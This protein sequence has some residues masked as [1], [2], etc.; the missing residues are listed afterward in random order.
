MHLLYIGWG[1]GLGRSGAEMGQ[2]TGCWGCGNDP[3]GSMKC[4][5]LVDQLWNEQLRKGSA[6]LSLFKVYLVTM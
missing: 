1:H 6:P 5:E 4:W 3:S 2:A